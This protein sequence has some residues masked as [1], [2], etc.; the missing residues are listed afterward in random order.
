MC[1]SVEIKYIFG[2]LEHEVKTLEHRNNLACT[3]LNTITVT[4]AN[5]VTKVKSVWLIFTI[6][7]LVPGS[8]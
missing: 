4:I 7:F 8:P 1:K 2:E 5:T 6:E 3:K